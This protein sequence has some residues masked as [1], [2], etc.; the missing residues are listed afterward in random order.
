MWTENIRCVFRVKS[1]F[2]IISSAAWTGPQPMRAQKH[3]LVG[4]NRGGNYHHNN[5][6]CLYTLYPPLVRVVH[7]QRYWAHL[8]SVRII[9]RILKQTV[10]R[11][12]HLTR[13]KEKE[14]SRWS[15]IIQTETTTTKKSFCYEMFFGQSGFLTTTVV[16][17]T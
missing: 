8:N 17:Q 4:N 15:A 11:I 9:C 10:V 1:S 7:I 2:S 5:R 3:L 14:L 6:Q 16:E 12:E 13:Q